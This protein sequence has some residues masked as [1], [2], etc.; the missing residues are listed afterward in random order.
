MR[1]PRNGGPPKTPTKFSSSRQ[2]GLAITIMII[3]L[4]VLLTLP[5]LLLLLIFIIIIIIITTRPAKGSLSPGRTTTRGRPA[6][7]SS[8]YICIYIYI[9]TLF[10]SILFYSII[11]CYIIIYIYIYIYI[12]THTRLVSNSAPMWPSRRCFYRLSFLI[13]EIIRKECNYD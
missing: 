13:R 6:S 1:G 2:G 10:Y 3:I 9:Y 7:A 12:C 8:M 5:L 4:L 11:L